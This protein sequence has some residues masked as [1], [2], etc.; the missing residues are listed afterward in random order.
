[1]SLI[2]YIE[3]IF[4][5]HVSVSL[6]SRETGMAEQLLNRAKVASPLEKVGGEGVP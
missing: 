5:I 2:I 4:W 6:S 3:Q 1:M